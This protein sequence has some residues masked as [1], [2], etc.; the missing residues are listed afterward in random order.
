MNTEYGLKAPQK[1]SISGRLS[2]IKTTYS[3]RADYEVSGVSSTLQFREGLLKEEINVKTL[4]HLKKMLRK[5]SNF[6]E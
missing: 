6:S 1:S 4:T 3:G 5:S 2:K